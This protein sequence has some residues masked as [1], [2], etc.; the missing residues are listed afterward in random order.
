MKGGIFLKLA[1]FSLYFYRHFNEAYGY[2]P[3]RG[4]TLS[5]PAPYANM[6]M[7]VATSNPT[8]IAAMAMPRSNSPG[9]AGI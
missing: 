2:G 8:G 5:S 7:S 3:N 6:G 9:P 4:R 1:I